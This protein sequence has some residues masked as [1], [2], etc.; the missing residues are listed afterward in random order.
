M[1]QFMAAHCSTTKYLFQVKKCLN[2]ECLY[3]TNH[4]VRLPLQH[5]KELSYVPLPLL[6]GE[7]YA[8]STDMYGKA[9]D[10]SDSPSTIPASHNEEIDKRRKAFLVSNLVPK[11][12]F[13][14]MQ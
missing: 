9:V 12:E 8:K 2:P 1:Q 7:K 6:H 11:L 14:D 13:Y 10:E 5:F 3:C 4:P